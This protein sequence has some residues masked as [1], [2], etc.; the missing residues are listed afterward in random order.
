MKLCPS[1]CV[2]PAS[3]Q[4]NCGAC[5]HDC[6]GGECVQ[7]RCQPVVITGGLASGATVFGVDAQYVYYDFSPIPRT[8][9]LYRIAKTA[10]NGTGTFLAEYGVSPQGVIGS[11]IL[12]VKDPFGFQSSCNVADCSNTLANLPLSGASLVDFRSPAPTSYTQWVTEPT[13]TMSWYTPPSTTAVT[14]YSDNTAPLYYTDESF[15]AYGKMVY[16]IRNILD[17]VG[18]RTDRVLYQLDSATKAR[19]QLGG[20][21]NANLQ[22]A[23]ANPISVLLQDTSTGN[24]Y[25]A[26]LPFGSGN[27]APPLLLAAMSPQ[28]VVEAATGIYWVD[29]GG[30]VYQCNAGACSG[31]QA[32]LTNGQNTYDIYQDETFLYWGTSGTNQVVRLVK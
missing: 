17:E 8:S 2:D 23:D 29:G 19:S 25:R 3:D 11:T 26:A 15:F 7:G 32:I 4:L 10:V 22:I 9:N 28:S 30:T 16:W 14:T 12:F 18:N 24:V 20:A 13:L 31:T 1:G 5:G 27:A 6:K 21:L